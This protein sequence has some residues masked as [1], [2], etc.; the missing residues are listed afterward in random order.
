VIRLDAR[1]YGGTVS[2]NMVPC[3]VRG[4]KAFLL[5]TDANEDGRGDHPKTVI[6][7]ACDVQLRDAF[8]LKDGDAVE[9]EIE[10]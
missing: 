4:R 3:T 5:R 7:I 10:R 6:E 9:I 2:V 8:G 1:E